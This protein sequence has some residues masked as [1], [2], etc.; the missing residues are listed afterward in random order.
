MALKVNLE[1]ITVVLHQPEYSENI[2]SAA[3]AMMNM[4]ICQLI[5]VEPS[6]FDPE[7]AAKLATH[8]AREILDGM[9]ICNCLK[10]A[11][12]DFEYVVGTTAR[13]GGQRVVEPPRSV[14]EKLVSISQENRVALL[15]GRE[16]RGLSNVDLRL[17][18]ALVNIPTASFSSLNLAQAVMVLCHE[19]FSVEQLDEKKHLPRLAGRNE[20]DMMYGE[21]EK[22]LA[23]ISY[24]NPENPDYWMNHLRLFFSR[25]HLQAKDVKIIRGVIRQFFRYHLKKSSSS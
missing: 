19:I 16:D 13:L 12:S 3:R 14:A 20:L 9:Q 5:V 7:A 8:A 17:C 10:D 15:F 1:N 23:E 11:L 6:D 24:I 18:H 22:M 4:G 21:I 25:I 2:G